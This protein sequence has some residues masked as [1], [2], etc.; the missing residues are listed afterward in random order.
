MIDVKVIKDSVIYDGKIYKLDD[1][2][3]LDDIIATELI[4]NGNVV[5]FQEAEIIEPDNAEDS[6]VEQDVLTGTLDAEDL[7]SMK[8]DDLVR[9]AQQ[10]GLD[11]KGTKDELIERISNVEVEVDEEEEDDVEE[12]DELPNT[13]MPD[14]E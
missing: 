3:K 14:E 4:K 7:K 6:Q 11:T 12:T 9:L 5:A 2:F 8:K 1:T 13:S 10:M